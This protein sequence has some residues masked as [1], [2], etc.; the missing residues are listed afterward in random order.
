MEPGYAT[1]FKPD[2]RS[3]EQAKHEAALSQGDGAYDPAFHTENLY[4]QNEGAGG[5]VLDLRT[6]K[7]IDNST[8]NDADLVQKRG[9]HIVNS[10]APVPS[11]ED[12]DAAAQWLAEHDK[13]A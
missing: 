5:E 4:D 13:A 1:E 12:N 11:D 2:E 9:G 7:P 6:G 10:D 8:T 3:Q